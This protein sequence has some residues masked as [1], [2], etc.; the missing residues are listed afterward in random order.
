MTV[1]LSVT[2][3]VKSNLKSLGIYNHLPFFLNG[4]VSP[5]V[6]YPAFNWNSLLRISVRLKLAANSLSV[7]ERLYSAPT[8]QLFFVVKF[9]P[10]NG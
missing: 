5:V 10:I 9:T 6:R 3:T 7:R 1:T 8:V 2:E 4:N